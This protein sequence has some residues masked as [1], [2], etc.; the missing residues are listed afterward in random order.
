[1]CVPSISG[2]R[3]WIPTLVEM[4]DWI[5]SLLVCVCVCV[6][7]YLS[8]YLFHPSSCLE[9]LTMIREAV[10]LGLF[11]EKKVAFRYK[12]GFRDVDG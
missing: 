8:I 10:L 4:A 5:V 1:M 7:V 3:W 12:K 9:H 11:F 2:L 6:C